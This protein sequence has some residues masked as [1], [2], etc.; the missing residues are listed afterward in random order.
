MSTHAPESMA[1]EYN[2]NSDHEWLASMNK[3]IRKYR[4]DPEQRTAELTLDSLC[5]MVDAYRLARKQ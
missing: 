3:A 5:R 4:R 2:G 1:R